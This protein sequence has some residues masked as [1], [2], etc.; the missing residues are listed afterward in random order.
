[1][2]WCGLGARQKRITSRQHYDTTY[3]QE[4]DTR[5]G[6]RP[7]I[8]FR[9]GTPAFQL[10]LQTRERTKMT[11]YQHAN[12]HTAEPATQQNLPHSQ[13]SHSSPKSILSLFSTDTQTFKCRASSILPIHAA[14]LNFEQCF[15]ICVWKWR[16]PKNDNHFVN[17]NLGI[18]FCKM[19]IFLKVI[20]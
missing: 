5:E 10:G 14:C 17:W 4:T 16:C 12:T 13:I 6:A 19:I 18:V 2:A 11:T 3:R 20:I 9:P 1:M 7:P 15:A 8:G